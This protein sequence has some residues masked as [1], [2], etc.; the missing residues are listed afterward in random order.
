MTAKLVECAYKCK[1]MKEEALV[2]V[3]ERR[4]DQ[5]VVEWVEKD[6]GFAIYL[7][8]RT[9]SPDCRETQM[10]YAKILVPS[11]IETNPNARIGTATPRN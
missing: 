8:H 3:P 1:C 4:A 2:F 6:M 11:D 7:H 9:N 10:E 5:D